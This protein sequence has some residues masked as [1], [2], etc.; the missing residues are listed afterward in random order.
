MMGGGGW[1]VGLI[2]MLFGI[3]VLVGIVLLIVWAVRAASGH[4]HAVGPT[5]PASHAAHEDA[6]AI[7]KRR[8][9]S[10]EITAEQYQEIMRALGG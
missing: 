2:M 4:G 10:G 1:I 5:P 9:A 3:A 8:L 6:V 7:A